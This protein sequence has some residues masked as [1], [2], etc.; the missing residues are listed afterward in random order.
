MTLPSIAFDRRAFL[1]HAGALTGLSVLPSFGGER[2]DDRALVLIQLSGGNDGLSMVVP[3][4]DDAT[5]ETVERRVHHPQDLAD[6]H[7]VVEQGPLELLRR[8]LRIVE[9]GQHAHHDVRQRWDAVGP[10]ED[11]APGAL[12]ESQFVDGCL[13]HVGPRVGGTPG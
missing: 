1:A 13:G 2:D 9:Q 3:H 12:P 6:Q 5:V 10:V 8:R 4:G 11:L 7:V